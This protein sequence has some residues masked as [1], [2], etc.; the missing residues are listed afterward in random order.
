MGL[1]LTGWQPTLLCVHGLSAPYLSLE[2][3]PFSSL[4]VHL[5]ACLDWPSTGGT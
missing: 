4:K 3:L 1:S 5:G 2:D